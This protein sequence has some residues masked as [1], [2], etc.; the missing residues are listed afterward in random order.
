V[1]AD[2][3]FLWQLAGRALCGAALLA[4]GCDQPRPPAAAGDPRTPPDSPG[5]VGAPAVGLEDVR[6]PE[7]VAAVKAQRGRVLV[8]DV[9]AEY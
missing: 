2:R 7:L 1:K 5:A 4:G 6:Y 9:W 3:F 8:V